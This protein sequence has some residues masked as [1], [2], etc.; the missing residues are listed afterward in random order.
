MPLGMQRR[1]NLTLPPQRP[2]LTA[3]A[4]LVTIPALYWRPE[5]GARKQLAL[6]ISARP[7]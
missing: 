5:F 2:R 7:C 4:N 6:G 3:P 1:I